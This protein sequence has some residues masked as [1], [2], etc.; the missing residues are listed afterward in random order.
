[1]DLVYKRSDV[2]KR[3]KMCLCRAVRQ[4]ARA[5]GWGEQL[6]AAAIATWDSWMRLRPKW[7][8]HGVLTFDRLHPAC[9]PD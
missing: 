1:M 8:G 5:V 6:W 4:V 9:G 3:S 7:H 2:P